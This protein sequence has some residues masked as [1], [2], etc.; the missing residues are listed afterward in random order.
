MRTT[1]QLSEELLQHV[2]KETGA[3]TMTQAI[4][5]ALQEYLEGRKRRRLIA[6][7]GQ[8]KDWQPDIRRMRR[9]RDLG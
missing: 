5:E 3:K 6:S 9:D 1:I 7:F 4:R 2:M 8:Y